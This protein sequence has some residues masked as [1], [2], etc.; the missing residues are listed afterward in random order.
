VGVLLAHGPTIDADSRERPAHIQP[1]GSIDA[2]QRAGLTDPITANLPQLQTYMSKG[3]YLR[4][5]LAK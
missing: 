4:R 3:A 5:L 2:N 1:I